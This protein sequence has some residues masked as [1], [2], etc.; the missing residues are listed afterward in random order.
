MFLKACAYTYISIYYDDG[1]RKEFLSYLI[2]K[3]YFC[4]Y[5]IIPKG[6]SNIFLGYFLLGSRIFLKIS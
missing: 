6:V 5:K 1:Y 4:L 3:F 2:F